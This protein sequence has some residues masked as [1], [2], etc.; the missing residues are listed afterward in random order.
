MRRLIDWV[1]KADRYASQL[2]DAYT[3]NPLGPNSNTFVHT[4][5]DHG[6]ATANPPDNAIGWDSSEFPLRPK[7]PPGKRP[8][9]LGPPPPTLPEPVP[10]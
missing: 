2:S 5:L 9:P 3:Y 4:L 6:D 7:P 8:I 1:V 10:V